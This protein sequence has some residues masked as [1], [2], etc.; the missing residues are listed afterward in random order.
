[1]F[2]DH[3]PRRRIRQGDSIP[4]MTQI[5]LQLGRDPAFENFL[6]AEVGEDPKGM[7]VTVLSMLARLDVDPWEEASDLTKMKVAAAQQRLEA[8]I[9]RFHD[10]PIGI[11]DRGKIAKNLL[12]FLPGQPKTARSAGD[13]AQIKIVLPTPGAPIYWVIT[14]IVLLGWLAMLAQ[15]S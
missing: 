13:A 8:L 1:M 15:G 5:P 11:V 2:I 14:V 9:A 6:S 12:T 10:V 7:S 4:D 3:S